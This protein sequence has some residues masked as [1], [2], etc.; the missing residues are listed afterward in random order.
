MFLCEGASSQQKGSVQNLSSFQLPSP[1]LLFSRLAARLPLSP[2][3]CSW[4]NAINLVSD[5]TKR[6]IDVLISKSTASIKVIVLST[7]NLSVCWL[8]WYLRVGLMPL[9]FQLGKK[10]K[11]IS[12]GLKFVDGVALNKLFWSGKGFHY[13]FTHHSSQNHSSLELKS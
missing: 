5:E 4:W 9:K 1:P 2:C 12:S 10:C 8:F 13:L 11:C 3:M 7:F 6:V